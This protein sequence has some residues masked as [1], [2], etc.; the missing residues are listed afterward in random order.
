[1]QHCLTHSLFGQCYQG[2][3]CPEGNSCPYLERSPRSQQNDES[4]G[5][6]ELNSR[7]NSGPSSSK[8]GWLE[9]QLRKEV[10]LAD[11]IELRVCQAMAMCILSGCKK[12]SSTVREITSCSFTVCIPALSNLRNDAIAARQR[13]LCCK[14][15]QQPTPA[16]DQSPLTQHYD[17]LPCIQRHDQLPLTP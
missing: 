13:V 17:Q 5:F 12:Q 11:P 3:R 2:S 9:Q 16:R 6:L 7:G 1:M 14:V 15:L 10:L 8:V 4:F